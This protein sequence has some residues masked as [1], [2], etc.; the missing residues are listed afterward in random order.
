MAVC[1]DLSSW[2]WN[3]ILRLRINLLIVGLEVKR[4]HVF[5]ENAREHLVFEYVFFVLRELLVEEAAYCFRVEVT[6]RANANAEASVAIEVH[7]HVAR[8]TL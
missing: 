4:L 6:R 1:R 5:V 7:V 3:L 8:D 2:W